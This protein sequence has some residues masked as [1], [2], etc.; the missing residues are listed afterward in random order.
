M[1]KRFYWIKLKE[2]FFQ[3][4]KIDWLKEQK[5]GCEYIVLYLQLC[6]MSANS[7]GILIRNIGEIMIPYDEKKIAEKTGFPVDTV[8][9]AFGLFRKLGLIFYDQD[10]SIV[11][12]EV[13]GV[14]GSE[15]ESAARVRKHR[16]I[17]KL[18]QSN[19]DVTACNGANLE[20]LHCNK[21]VTESVTNPMLQSNENGDKRDKK[22]QSNKKVTE[23]VTLEKEIDKCSSLS[24]LKEK[25]ERESDPESQTAGKEVVDLYR[26]NVSPMMGEIEFERLIDCISHYGPVWTKGAI[27]TAVSKGKRSLA[28][29]EGILKNWEVDGHGKSGNRT[30]QRR[31]Q[32]KTRKVTDGSET[33]WD[34]EAGKGW[35]D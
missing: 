11:L 17:K 31:V 7:N 25:Q 8:V 10:G 13:Q 30:G 5:N 4:D 29:I 9:V 34:A 20:T 16:A 19:I 2:N 24:S 26:N 32:R 33:D 3:Q 15:C 27:V 28:Y 12:P 21:K 22:L 1:S 35:D 6:L 18:L 23:S 14:V